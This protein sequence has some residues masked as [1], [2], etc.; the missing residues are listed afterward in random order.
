MLLNNLPRYYICAQDL[1]NPAVNVKVP[2]SVVYRVMAITTLT[3]AN[4]FVAT[5]YWNH[6][7]EQI[8]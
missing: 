6:V 3:C 7:R 8:V 2:R 5:A 1:L 4:A